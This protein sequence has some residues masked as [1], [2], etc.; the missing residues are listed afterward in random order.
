MSKKKNIVGVVY[1]TNPDFQYNYEQ[2]SETETLP[3][4][5]QNLKVYIERKHRGG[6][7]V[8]VIKGFIGKQDD[9]EII[10]KMLKT[11]CGVGG[12]TKDNEIVIQGELREKV[13][14]ILTEAGYHVKKAGG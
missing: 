9:L 7:T 12:T 3:P 4:Q 5:Q 13:Y 8:T 1:S 2:R 11:R 6:K 14:N 10:A